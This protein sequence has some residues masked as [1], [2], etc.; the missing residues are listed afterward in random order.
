[1]HNTRIIIYMIIWAHINNLLAVGRRPASRRAP[2]RA[3]CP[4][5]RTVG[6]ARPPAGAL[7]GHKLANYAG[8]IRLISTCELGSASSSYT[9][10]IHDVSMSE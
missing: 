8:A 5:A 7:S 1:M 4:P 6:Q 9:H 3:A 2:G 10:Y